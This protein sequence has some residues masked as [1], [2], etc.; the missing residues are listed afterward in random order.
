[1]LEIESFNDLELS[2]NREGSPRTLR[3]TPASV[4][5]AQQVKAFATIPDWGSC[6]FSFC[7]K[8][9]VELDNCGLGVSKFGFASKKL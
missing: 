8:E 3:V 4:S 6:L 9:I 1:M 5:R 2:L 7:L